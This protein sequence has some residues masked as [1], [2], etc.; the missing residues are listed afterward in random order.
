VLCCDVLEHLV[1]PGA[2]LRGLRT[3]DSPDGTLHVSTPNARHW[4]LMRDLLV[5]GTFAFAEGGHRDATHLRWFTRQEL[6]VLIERSGWHV[7]GTTPSLAHFLRARRLPAPHGLVWRAGELFAV[8]WFV[9]ARAD[10]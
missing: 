6:V 4:T 9:L 5:R 10:R 7:E 3:T 8:Q 1:E 2:L